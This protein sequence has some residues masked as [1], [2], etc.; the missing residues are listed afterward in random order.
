MEPR[1][2]FTG[3]CGRPLYLI[4]QE[5]SMLSFPSLW[6]QLFGGGG[7]LMVPSGCSKSELKREKGAGH[8]PSVANPSLH[9][10]PPS[11]PLVRRM[12]FREEPL[13][14]T[15]VHGPPSYHT[16]SQAHVMGYSGPRTRYQGCFPGIATQT[17]ATGLCPPPFKMR[18]RTMNWFLYAG[19]AQPVHPLSDPDTLLLFIFD[20]P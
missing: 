5:V 6:H 10:H 13:R 18:V 12:A 9:H 2:F 11:T 8:W 15:S 16:N 1:P 14:Q 3:L 4:L 20:V 7:Q 17:S 19:R